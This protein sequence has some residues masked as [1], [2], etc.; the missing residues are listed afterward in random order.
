MVN[1]KIATLTNQFKLHELKFQNA[2][3][4]L[5]SKLVS[6]HKPARLRQNLPQLQTFAS[7]L[8]ELA[9]QVSAHL[10]L[11]ELEPD[12]LQNWSLQEFLQISADISL[13]ILQF[14]DQIENLT[15]TELTPAC[16]S[17]SSPAFTAIQ[18]RYDDFTKTPAARPSI[19][20]QTD[21]S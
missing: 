20:T 18:L 6:D 17:Q 4:Y 2:S 1:P 3:N 13:Q 19:S 7:R 16:H 21:S 10:P 15:F 11:T 9:E 8:E 5:S 14:S 12:F